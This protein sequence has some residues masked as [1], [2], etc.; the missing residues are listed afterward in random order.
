MNAVSQGIDP[1]TIELGYLSDAFYKLADILIFELVRDLGFGY[2]NKLYNK[3]PIFL[4]LSV[5]G[6]VGV[7]LNAPFS[8]A[9]T[10]GQ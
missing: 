6:V 5:T 10:A 2:T 8:L 3:A 4:R 9:M 1:Y 7:I